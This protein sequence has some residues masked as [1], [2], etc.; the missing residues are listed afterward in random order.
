MFLIGHQVFKN[1]MG[2]DSYPEPG[3]VGWVPHFPPNLDQDTPNFIVSSLQAIKSVLK[4]NM[5]LAG[6][7]S[8]DQIFLAVN[9]RGELEINRRI[10][11]TK[12]DLPVPGDILSLL[13]SCSVMKI[14]MFFLQ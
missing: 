12:V 3:W 4:R 13:V 10:L 11:K 14:S 1:R 7:V 2:K 5:S 8:V 6:V 9:A